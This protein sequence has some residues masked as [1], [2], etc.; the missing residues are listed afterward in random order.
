MVLAVQPETMRS[1][2]EEE[3][4]GVGEGRSRTVL[5]WRFQ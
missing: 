4:E 5:R 2:E 1:E 3:V